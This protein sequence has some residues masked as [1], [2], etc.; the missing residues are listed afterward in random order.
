MDYEQISYERRGAAALITIERPERMNAI[1]A[2]THRELVDA[3]G[4][5]REE[6]E[7]L[8][9]ILTG[10]GDRAFSAGG[11]GLR[12]EAEC[13]NRLLGEPEILEGLRR[14]NER[15][16]PDREAGEDPATRGLR[17]D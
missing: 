6:D 14:F 15:D 5:F 2:R 8:V 12:I 9:G 17:R 13:F 3:W 4:R 11:E 16:H 1:G 7:A 10:A